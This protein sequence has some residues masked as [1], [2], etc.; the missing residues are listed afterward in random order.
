[1]KKSELLNRIA[2]KLDM[3]RKDVERVVDEFINTLAEGLRK[4]NKVNVA[5]LGI[6]SVRDRKARMARNPKTGETVHVPAKKVVKFRVSK[7]MKTAVL[8]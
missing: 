5:G 1:M 3:K 4:E 7:D 2:T 8:G 6:F